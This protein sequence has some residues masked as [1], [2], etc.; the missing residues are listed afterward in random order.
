MGLFT[1]KPKVVSYGEITLRYVFKDLKFFEK[2]VAIKEFKKFCK[3]YKVQK[4]N[5]DNYIKHIKRG[6]NSWTVFVVFGEYEEIR[7]Y[8]KRAEYWGHGSIW[9]DG[10]WHDVH[11]YCLRKLTLVSKDMPD[12]GDKDKFLKT[13]T[14]LG[15][16]DN[17]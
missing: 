6:G 3:K 11:E 8:I 16:P 4:V 1:K 15:K 14:T 9:S 10:D 7:E 5:R 13:M 2:R 17:V 12:P